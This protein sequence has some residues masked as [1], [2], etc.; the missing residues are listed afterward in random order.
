MARCVGIANGETVV[1]ATLGTMVYLD[2]TCGTANL[3]Y[4]SGDITVTHGWTA[5]DRAV[6]K[7][8]RDNTAVPAGCTAD[9]M[10][11]D[12]KIHAVEICYETDIVSSGE[13]E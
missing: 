6:V 3:M 8:L 9:N 1:G 5:G 11:V 12:A 4:E 2:D 13:G 10:Q 7:L